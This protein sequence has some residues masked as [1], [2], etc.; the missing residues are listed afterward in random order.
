VKI[1]IAQSIGAQAAALKTLVGGDM[2]VVLQQLR[3]AAEDLRPYAIGL[4]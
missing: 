2:G 3:D 1:E 4:E